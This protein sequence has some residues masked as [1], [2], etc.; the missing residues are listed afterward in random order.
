MLKTTTAR[1][2]EIR[3][4]A[5]DIAPKL[6]SHNLPTAELEQSITAMKAVEDALTKKDGVGIHTAY[7]SAVD[8]LSRS[9]GA[10]GKHVVTQRT[11]DATLARRLEEM[12]SQGAAHPFKGYEQIISAYFEALAH[13]DAGGER[14]AP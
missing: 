4:A 11:Q 2:I 12:Q 10:V 9:R 7:T 6:R 14:G 5:Q 1:Q 13:Q 3:R 8:S